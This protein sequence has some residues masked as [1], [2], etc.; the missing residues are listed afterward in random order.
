[1]F[2]MACR[3]CLPKDY[4]M[5]LLSNGKYMTISK[6]NYKELNRRLKFKLPFLPAHGIVQVEKSYGKLIASIYQN[7][8][9]SEDD[10]VAL[11]YINSD[12][13]NVISSIEELK[14]EKYELEEKEKEYP[15]KQVKFGGI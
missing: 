13:E 14:D 2:P 7:R 8:F 11:A 6:P 10:K 1:M 15:F 4:A 3:K 5:I 9:L 12:I